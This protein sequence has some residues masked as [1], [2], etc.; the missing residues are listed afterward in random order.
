[1]VSLCGGLVTVDEQSGIVR[2]VHYTTQESLERTKEYW[3]PNAETNIVNIC[4]TYLS[5]SIFKKGIPETD[6]EFERRLQ[7]NPLYDYAMHNWGHHARIASMSC[8]GIVSRVYRLSPDIWIQTR[9]LSPV[10]RS[11]V[12]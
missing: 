10:F 9:I 5:F 2:L 3:F 11:P 8:H 7:S 6:D 12:L 4:I 1:M